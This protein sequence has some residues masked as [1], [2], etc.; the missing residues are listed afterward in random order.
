MSSFSYYFHSPFFKTSFFKNNNELLLSI[1]LLKKHKI[2]TKKLLRT[3]LIKKIFE[4][5]PYQQ[6]TFNIVLNKK[7]K[8]IQP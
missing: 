4:V 7:L 6:I 2:H 5:E 3:I 8:N 1:E